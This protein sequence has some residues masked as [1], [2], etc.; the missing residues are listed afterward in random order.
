MVKLV[1]TRLPANGSDDKLDVAGLV[2]VEIALLDSRANVVSPAASVD[3]LPLLVL[4]GPVGVV[5]LL[6]L[7]PLFVGV[8]VF[9][10]QFTLVMVVTQP[11][12]RLDSA[13]SVGLS[14]PE[15]AVETASKPTPNNIRISLIQT[16][17]T[18]PKWRFSSNFTLILPTWFWRDSNGLKRRRIGAESL[19][20]GP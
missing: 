19:P 13:S 18:R 4:V 9:G 7:E 20:I 10:V 16:A 5:V 15:S 14:Q 12:V 2:G 3:V 8:T 1:P 11:F 17:Q 6:L